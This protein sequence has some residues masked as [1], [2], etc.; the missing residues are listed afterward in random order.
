MQFQTRIRNGQSKKNKTKASTKKLNLKTKKENAKIAEAWDKLD[1]NKL[2]IEQFLDTM[3][4][5]EN[6]DGVHLGI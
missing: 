5:F 4:E 6:D 3:S 2:S 1:Q